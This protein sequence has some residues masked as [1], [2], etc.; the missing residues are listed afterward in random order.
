MALKPC[1]DCGTLS[2]G[3]R[4]TEHRRA[5]DRAR[6]ADRPSPSQRGY[7][8]AWRK[9]RDQHLT[10]EPLCRWCRTA[11]E[12]DNPLTVDHITPKSR[13]G[14]DDPANLRT[15][16]K[17]CHGTKPRRERQEEEG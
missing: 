5:R 11:G 2:D 6:E 16:C 7:G 1:L 13:G 9:I 12:P 8:H 10:E 14:T 17:R 15:L 3:P 4:C